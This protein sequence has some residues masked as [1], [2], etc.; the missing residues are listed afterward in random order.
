M[1]RRDRVSIS[2][3]IYMIADQSEHYC[4]ENNIIWYSL[5]NT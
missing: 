5:F 1:F 3:S 2:M 4:F